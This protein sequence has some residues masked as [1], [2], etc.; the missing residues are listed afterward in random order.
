MEPPDTRTEVAQ[1]IRP[2]TSSAAKGAKSA[3][4]G[5]GADAEAVCKVCGECGHAAGFVG[6]VYLDCPVMACYLCKQLGHTTATCAHRILPVVPMGM[7]RLDGSVAIALRR[8]SLPPQLSHAWSSP[9]RMTMARQTGAGSLVPVVAAGRVAAALAPSPYRQ[10]QP[11]GG[12]G[13]GGASAA[14]MIHAPA[15]SVAACPWRV[16]AVLQVTT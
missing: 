1:P 3:Q 15:N 13:C 5:R 6:A 12:F 16:T 8:L 14:S 9:L 11:P 2:R 10:R 7:Q 4:R